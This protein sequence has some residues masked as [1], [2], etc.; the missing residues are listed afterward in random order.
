MHPGLAALLE[1]VLQEGQRPER[2]RHSTF[3]VSIASAMPTSRNG[4]GF[5]GTGVCWFCGVPSSRLTLNPGYLAREPPTRKLSTA[6]AIALWVAWDFVEATPFSLASKG[7]ANRKNN[8]PHFWWGFLKQTPKKHHVAGAE[9]MKA[10]V[11]ISCVHRSRDPPLP[12]PRRGATNRTWEKRPP[13]RRPKLGREATIRVFF[14]QSILVG[15]PLPKKKGKR[16]LLG[17]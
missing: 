9:E 13:K 14:L 10:M 11:S 5:I 16:A 1:R 7:E 4:I 3:F 6:V 2:N 8:T 17:T 15:E 12:P